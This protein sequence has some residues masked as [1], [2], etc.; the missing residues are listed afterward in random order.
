MFR[1]VI[2]GFL[3]KENSVFMT[4]LL[5]FALLIMLLSSC[6]TIRSRRHYKLTVTSPDATARVVYNDST[7]QLPARIRVRRSKA[8]LPLLLVTDSARRKF[9]VKS[10]P[11]AAFVFGNLIFMELAPAAY[12]I[13]LTTQKRFHYGTTL[14][15][16]MRDTA[17]TIRPRISEKGHR[18][19]TRRWPVA[20]GDVMLQVSLPLVNNFYLKPD[21]EGLKSKTGFYGVAAAVGYAYAP[22]RFLGLTASALADREVPAPEPYDRDGAYEQ[23]SAIVIAITDNRQLRRFTFGYGL[24]YAQNTW[25]GIY[26]NSHSGPSVPPPSRPSVRKS[27]GSIGLMLSGHYQISRLANAGIV[28]RPGL[29][30]LAP[31]IALCYQHTLSLDLALTLRLRHKPGH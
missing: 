20:K 13:D 4:R 19:F 7:Y 21:G 15:L 3:E 9:V 23:L 30:T 6:A 17:S 8:D 1:V 26:D 16:D 31:D 11:D 14:Q 25:R 5:M 24:S 29:L 12:L 22:G 2:N 18:F 28:Y 27:A 10:V